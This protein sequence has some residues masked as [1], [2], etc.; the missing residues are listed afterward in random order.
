[1]KKHQRVTFSQVS[2]H[3]EHAIQY[4]NHILV[5]LDGLREQDLT[6]RV[7]LLLSSYEI[8]Q[9]KLLGAIERYVEDADDRL[10][11]T[12]AQNAVELPAEL[13]GPEAP[14]TTLSLTRWLQSI[15]QHLVSLFHE[16]AETSRSADRRGAFEAMTRQIEAHERKL[17]KEYQRFEDL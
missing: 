17:S 16:L 6:D 10:M 12:Y 4:L 14:L 15:N 13:D 9:R 2:D 3:F 5:M 7:E 8:E 11:N 1:M